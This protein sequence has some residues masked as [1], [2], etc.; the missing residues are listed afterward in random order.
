[1]LV[2]TSGPTQGYRVKCKHCGQ[3]TGIANGP[4]AAMVIGGA[5]NA[6]GSGVKFGVIRVKL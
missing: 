3:G 5:D 2:Y 6:I 1:M 4:T